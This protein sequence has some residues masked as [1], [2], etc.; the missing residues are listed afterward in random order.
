MHT[1][2]LAN[3]KFQ[4]VCGALLGMLACWK[5]LMPMKVVKLAFR[6][7]GTVSWGKR[8]RGEQHATLHCVI[9]LASLTRV[10]RLFCVV[11]AVVVGG[12]VVGVGVVV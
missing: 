12:G 11:P 2:K 8:K 7:V 6:G 1:Q 4:V 9:L 3:S 10:Q 5:N